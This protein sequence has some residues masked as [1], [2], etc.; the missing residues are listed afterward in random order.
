ML[1]LDAI[2]RANPLP[3]VAGKH[4]KLIR[5]G[6]EWKACCPFH[7]DRTPSFTIFAG[8]DR[9]HCFGCG[10]TGDVLDFVQQLDGV[11]LIEAAS[12]LSGGTAPTSTFVNKSEV[13]PDPA[14]L[15]RISTARSIW[16]AAAPADGTLA[17]RY[18]A[19]RSIALT[20]PLCVRFARLPYGRAAECYPCLVA[21]VTAP[22]G[23]LCGIQRTYLASDGDGKAALSKPKLSLGRIAG[24]AIR[25]S[26]PA[27]TLIVTEGLED[28]LSASQIFGLPAW[29]AAGVGMLAKMQLPARVRSVIIGADND[30]A[31]QAGARKAAETFSSQGRLV[32]IVSPTAGAKDFNDELRRATA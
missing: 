22:D 15:A 13:Q 19:S 8:G 26:D 30:E 10:A 2:R 4:A 12:R 29:A 6:A 18:L 5:A 17:A 11:G 1:D 16:E 14:E 21:A 32:R 28:A 23:N 7:A 20:A 27:E 9:F 24:G 31:G 3:A 25:C